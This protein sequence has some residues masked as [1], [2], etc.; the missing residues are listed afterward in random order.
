MDQY[1]VEGSHGND[2]R[3]IRYDHLV[4]NKLDYVKGGV[5]EVEIIPNEKR[6]VEEKMFWR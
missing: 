1:K 6:Q 2:I 4:I 5:H 3:V